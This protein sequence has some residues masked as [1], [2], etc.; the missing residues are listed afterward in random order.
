VTSEETVTVTDPRHPLFNQTFPLLSIVN[1]RDVGH[2]CVVLV[3]GISRQFVPVT[4]TNRSAIPVAVWPVPL[5]LMALQQLVITYH[6]MVG[7]SEDDHPQSTTGSTLSTPVVPECTASA[8][9][10]L[11]AA[12]PNPTAAGLPHPGPGVPPMGS[13]DQESGA[14]P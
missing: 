2:C 4:A 3:E 8:S 12:Q 11:G 10:S 9:A 6:Q 5:N 13:P 14:T 1:R 7:S